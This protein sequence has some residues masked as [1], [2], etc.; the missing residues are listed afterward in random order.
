MG[1]LGRAKMSE[2]MGLAFKRAVRESKPL[3]VLGTIN[4]Y[5]ALLA[6]TAGAKAL[7]V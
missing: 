1:T 6:Q 5:S 3:Q 7:Y 4:A 2:S